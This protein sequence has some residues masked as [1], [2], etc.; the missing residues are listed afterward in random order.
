MHVKRKF[1]SVQ[2]INLSTCKRF[3]LDSSLTVATFLIICNIPYL[4]PE[5][6]HCDV[7]LAQQRLKVTSSVTIIESVIYFFLTVQENNKR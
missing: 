7:E 4:K 5:Q 6:L 2:T 1:V 3:T